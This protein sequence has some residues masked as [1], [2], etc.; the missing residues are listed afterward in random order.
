[1]AIRYSSFFTA[2]QQ[3]VPGVYLD[4]VQLANA[5]PGENDIISYNVAVDYHMYMSTGAGRSNINKY[6]NGDYKI[7]VFCVR[8][9]PKNDYLNVK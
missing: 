6:F 7:A 5:S 4:Q 1:M 3:D 8:T 2:D 9:S